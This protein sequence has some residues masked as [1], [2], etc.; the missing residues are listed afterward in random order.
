MSAWSVSVGILTPFQYTHPSV[1]CA[2]LSLVAAHSFRRGGVWGSRF[3]GG[4][5]RACVLSALEGGGGC[6]G[7]QGPR[8]MARPAGGQKT[9]I[10][11]KFYGRRSME[12]S[13]RKE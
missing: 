3:G 11:G 6:L 5:V 1:R 4:G 10:R 12:V 8:Y 7:G 2:S 9:K 13:G